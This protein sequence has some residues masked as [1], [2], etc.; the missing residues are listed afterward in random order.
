MT[1]LDNVFNAKLCCKFYCNY[2][3]YGTSKKSSYDNHNDSKRHKTNILTTI[4]NDS[5]AK[6]C[7]K[8]YS[9]G[10]CDK[11]FND[12]AG[13]WRH[14]KKC[15]IKE[16]SNISDILLDKNIILELIK[17][18]TEIQKTNDRNGK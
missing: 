10:N 14:K 12:R 11:D 13:L 18:N 6:L 16:C 17:S 1:T 5:D 9:C 7:Q 15:K 8:K 4:D 3:H 2:C